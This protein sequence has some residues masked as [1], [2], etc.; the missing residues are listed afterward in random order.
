LPVKGTLLGRIFTGRREVAAFGNLAAE[1]SRSARPV[2]E[3]GQLASLLAV[4]LVVRARV[5]GV[6]CVFAGRG[7]RYAPGDR[8]LLAGLARSA[9]LAIENAQVH[10]K[11]RTLEEALRETERSALLSALAAGL[12]HEIRNPLT[13]LRIL[14]DSVVLCSGPAAPAG[15]VL[16][17][18]RQLDRLE[19]I[20]N[21]YLERARAQAATVQAQPLDLNGVIGEALLLLATQAGEGTRMVCTLHPGELRMRG[22]ATQLSQ[23]VYNLVLNALQAVATPEAREAGGPRRVEIRSGPGAGAG[24]EVF[25]EVA[26]NGPGLAPEVR[27]QLFRPFVSTKPQGV[28]LGLSIVKRVVDAH[29]GRLAIESPRADLGCR[30][31]TVRVTFPAAGG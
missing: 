3:A 15:D 5:L 1:V 31:T 2:L 26:D 17:I 6:L 21:Q 12:A 28:G 24:G 27:E 4:R 19:Q 11:M 8:G 16:M 7:R 9:A 25:F 30:G 18:R 10:R 29:G 20:V 13:S 22:D 23:V 14:F